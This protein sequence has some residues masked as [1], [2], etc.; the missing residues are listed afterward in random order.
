M[1]ERAATQQAAH[2]YRP[3]ARPKP[4]TAHHY[5]YPQD[6]KA[7]IAEL[8]LLVEIKAASAADQAELQILENRRISRLQRLALA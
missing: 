3:S 7:R 2:D 5:H 1:L 4:R 8:E 6:L